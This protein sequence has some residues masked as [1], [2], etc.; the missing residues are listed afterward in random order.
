MGCDIHWYS[1]T[2]RA[3]GQWQCD[4]AASF[5]EVEEEDDI[6]SYSDLDVFPNRDRDYWLFGL[7]NDGVRTEWP[8][9]FQGKGFPNSASREV[10]EVFSSWRD[11]AHSASFLTRAELKAKLQELK[12]I[13]AEYMIRSDVAIHEREAIEHHAK[14][15][16]EIINNLSNESV[17]D[18]SQRIVFWFDN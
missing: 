10:A 5:Q 9:S 12:P 17:S 18:E 15:L 14:R 8:Y 4:Q 1:E 11:D 13:R 6:Y 7:L 2:R 3:D 16:Q